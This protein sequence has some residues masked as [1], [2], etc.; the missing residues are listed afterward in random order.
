MN[1]NAKEFR[2]FKEKDDLKS[3]LSD[4]DANELI[5]CIK[6]NI[7][8]NR[9]TSI[10][11]RYQKEKLIYYLKKRQ[12]ICYVYE[13]QVLLDLFEDGIDLWKSERALDRVMYYLQD[14]IS[15]K[16]ERTQSFPEIEK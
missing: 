14:N 10:M 8:M 11:V 12:K 3:S 2:L 1:I 9:Q 6:D 16:M 13:L 4:A 5:N 7:E 15:I